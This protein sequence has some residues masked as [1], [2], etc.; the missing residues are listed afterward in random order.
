MLSIGGGDLYGGFDIKTLPKVQFL[1]SE[2]SIALLF[3]LGTFLQVTS[4][5]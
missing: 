5:L 2:K 3:P 4:A 1:S